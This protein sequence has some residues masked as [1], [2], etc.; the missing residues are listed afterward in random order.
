[1]IENLRILG[2][3]GGYVLAPCHNIQS[4]GPAENVVAMYEAGYEYGWLGGRLKVG[5]LKLKVR[6]LG[7]NGSSLPPSAD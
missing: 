6:D 5:K 7:R 2:G 1:M 4:V 3:G